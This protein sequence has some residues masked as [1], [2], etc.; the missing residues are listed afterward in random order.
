MLRLKDVD[1]ERFAE[2]AVAQAAKTL[3][4]AGRSERHIAAKRWVLRTLAREVAV[5][6]RDRTWNL[7]GVTA[8]VGLAALA[9]LVYGPRTPAPS[10][11][12]G[13]DTRVF[14]DLCADA[15]L[16]GKCDDLVKFV[17]SCAAIVICIER[18]NPRPDF[19]GL[20][21]TSKTYAE[22]EAL[23][24]AGEDDRVLEWSVLPRPRAQA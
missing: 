18:G 4:A 16:T 12:P 8:D 9:V 21:L 2:D 14:S 17:I 10:D 3:R 5:L 23:V 13:Q 7:K 6:A 15:P 11:D 19:A 24:V 1:I 20:D 22:V